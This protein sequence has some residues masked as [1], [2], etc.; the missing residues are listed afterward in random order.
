MRSSLRFYRSA[1]LAGAI[2][3]LAFFSLACLG[4]VEGERASTGECPAG[5]TCSDATPE[6]LDF[7]GRAFFDEPILRLGPVIVGG[8]FELGLRT[9]DGA[10]LPDFAATGDGIFRI[11][12]GDEV[13]GPTTEDGAAYYVVDAH[14]ELRA[15][16]A[17]VAQ[18]RITDPSTGALLD[19]LEI[20]AVNLEEVDVVVAREP[21]RPHLYAGC[22]EMIGV[23]LTADNGTTSVR[24]FDEGMRVRADGVELEEEPFFWDCVVYSV[25]AD[26]SE[27]AID[28]EVAGRSFRH[29]MQVASLADDGLTE[30]PAAAD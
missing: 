25:P 26:A 19:R 22:D 9:R 12:S 10:P 3:I 18:V 1:R 14:L 16:R 27:V 24:G 15:V 8:T 5:E 7:V 30:C 21:E 28:V 20:E 23:H 11:A 13:F 17:G 2:S 4:E 6:G 29:T